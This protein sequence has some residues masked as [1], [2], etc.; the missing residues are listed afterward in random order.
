MK[1]RKAV[2]EQF[3]HCALVQRVDVNVVSKIVSVYVK[4]NSQLSAVVLRMIYDRLLKVTPR[5]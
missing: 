5:A 2:V 3:N 4:S 1:L